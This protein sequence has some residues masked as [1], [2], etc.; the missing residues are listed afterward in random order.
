MVK[1]KAPKKTMLF[2][3][4]LLIAACSAAWGMPNNLKPE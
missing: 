1:N 3:G 4:A 2:F